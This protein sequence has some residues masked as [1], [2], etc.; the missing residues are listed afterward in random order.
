MNRSSIESRYCI[1]VG[2]LKNKKMDRV[3]SRFFLTN[4][5]YEKNNDL[6]RKKEEKENEKK[7]QKSMAVFMNKYDDKYNSYHNDEEPDF[8]RNF[9]TF[10][11]GERKEEN[12][13]NNEYQNVASHY[14]KN[15]NKETDYNQLRYG[16]TICENK[17]SISTS[18][19]GYKGPVNGRTESKQMN[20]VE[21]YE[22]MVR[23]NDEKEDEKE[24]EERMRNAINENDGNR[25]NF[26]DC[27]RDLPWDLHSV[28]FLFEVRTYSREKNF[29]KEFFSMLTN[30]IYFFHTGK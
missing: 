7:N 6:L 13:Y 24:E 11:C 26:S 20:Y 21:K 29:C 1:A 23:D 15:G 28:R 8:Y 9:R 19:D 10:S 2:I 27:D 5:L 30:W 18:T 3:I 17:K 4:G 12:N 16:P 22:K 14:R 25:N